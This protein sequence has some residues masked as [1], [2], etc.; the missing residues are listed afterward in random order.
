MGSIPSHFQIQKEWEATKREIG[1]WSEKE[2]PLLF[3]MWTCIILAEEQNLEVGLS[4]I[5]DSV[6]YIFSG[7]SEKL[8]HAW[9]FVKIELKGS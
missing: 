4:D 5:R 7:R 2:F 9:N 6:Y 8:G 1:I 3:P